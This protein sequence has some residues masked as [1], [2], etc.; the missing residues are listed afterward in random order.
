MLGM[1]ETLESCDGIIRS[2]EETL[3]KQHGNMEKQHGKTEEMKQG[4]KSAVGCLNAICNG[5]MDREMLQKKIDNLFEQLQENEDIE[6]K[7]ECKRLWA[8]VAAQNMKIESLE[9]TV[10][11]Q[12]DATRALVKVGKGRQKMHGGLH[13]E[14]FAVLM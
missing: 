10:D 6:T 7:D 11:N 5:P 13:E 3:V 4:L 12:K 1:F 9:K 14:L 2:F 8:L